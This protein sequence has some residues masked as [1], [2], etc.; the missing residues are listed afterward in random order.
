MVLSAL[1]TSR[2]LYAL[3]CL[4]AIALA[5]EALLYLALWHILLRRVVPMFDI[6]PARYVF[7][8]LTQAFCED[9]NRLCSCGWVTGSPSQGH[10]LLN[11]YATIV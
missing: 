5:V 9:D 10:D 11:F 8:C 2:F 1:A 7:I 6:Y 4:V 3:V